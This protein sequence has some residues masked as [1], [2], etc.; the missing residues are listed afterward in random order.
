MSR[1]KGVYE[2]ELVL[3][4]GAEGATIRK[5]VT[6]SDLGCSLEYWD[7]ASDDERESMLYSEL[8]DWAVSHIECE[9]VAKPERENHVND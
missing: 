3:G 8:R 4:V 5:E 6:V 9:W 7:A 2:Y 1:T